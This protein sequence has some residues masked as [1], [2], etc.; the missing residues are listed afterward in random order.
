MESG[1]AP[2]V[3]VVV[4]SRNDDH[5]ENMLMR[6]RAMVE[7]WM[8]Q[9]EQCGLSSEVVV[10]EWNPPAGRLRLA[11]VLGP[12][13]RFANCQVRFIEVEPQIHARF[14]NAGV[15][16]LHQ[17]IAKNAGIRRARGEFVLATNI[18]IIFSAE[19]MRFLAERRLEHGVLY[20]IDRHDVSK[21]L[22]PGASVNELLAFCEQHTLR[23][24]ARDGEFRLS[25]DGRR[26]LEPRDIV[27][28]SA[29][30]GFQE[31]WSA[32]QDSG[33]ELY[34][35]VDSEATL[36]LDKLRGQSRALRL[37]AEAGPSAGD[38]PVTMELVDKSGNTMA[39]AAIKGRADVR[40]QMPPGFVEDA[41]TFRVHGAGLPI[42]GQPRIANLRVLALEW[43]SALHSESGAGWSMQP[44]STGPAV[45]WAGS[46]DA[47][48]PFAQEIQN[49]AHLHI[50]GCG[51][52][53]LLSRADWFRLRGYAEFPIWPMHID[54]L[55]CYTA[56]H[57][58]IRESILS[59]PKK[60]YHIEHSSPAGW[61][62]EGERARAARIQASGVPEMTYAE[63]AQWIDLMRRYDSPALFGLDSWGLGEFSLPET[64]MSC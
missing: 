60:I 33:G 24:F 52:F 8:E 18:D 43:D 37:C 59:A 63:L 2:Y 54:A 39:A 56:H 1:N 26:M 49:A 35:W 30:I 22:P 28:Q 45:N 55:L 16:P 13:R 19:L 3:S 53:T 17:M 5:G 23:V 29:G 47:P 41:L 42:K 21:N 36:L 48:S 15:I 9:A 11:D 46:F 25:S 51:D 40:I 14:S 38:A 32:V 4:T 57:A 62:A 6:M 20:R 44:V 34:R 12:F 50:N 64:N 7:S 27:S 10:V 58:G 61:T 31:G